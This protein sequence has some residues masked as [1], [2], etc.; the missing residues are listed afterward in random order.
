[1]KW[2]VSVVAEWLSAIVHEHWGQMCWEKCG[3]CQNC[4]QVVVAVELDNHH[5][6]PMEVLGPPTWCG[7]Q[8][9][10]SRVPEGLVQMLRPWWQEQ[11]QGKK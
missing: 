5:L 7:G 6:N 1:M 2:D 3:S 8:R 9:L 4:V 10:K 11:V